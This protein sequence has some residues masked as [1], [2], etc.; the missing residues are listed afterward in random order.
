MIW[1]PA[2][3]SG[4]SGAIEGEPEHTGQYS[5]ILAIE[6]RAKMAPGWDAKVGSY[7]CAGPKGEAGLP[8][9]AEAL[10][11]PLSPSGVS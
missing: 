5:R 9:P 4:L 11:W 2:W 10:R 3:E 7:F 6:Q 1:R 8:G